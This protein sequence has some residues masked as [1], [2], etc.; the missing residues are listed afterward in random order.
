[1]K[2]PLTSAQKAEV[3]ALVAQGWPRAAAELM[4]VESAPDVITG[5]PPPSTKE[6]ETA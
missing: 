4:V 3:E 1:M 2:L 5:P 6:R